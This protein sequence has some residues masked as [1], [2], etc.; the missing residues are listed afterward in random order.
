MHQEGQGRW[1]HLGSAWH[2]EDE[3]L[4]KA[5]GVPIRAHS[6]R[7]AVPLWRRGHQALQ[8]ISNADCC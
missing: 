1:Q 2:G 5:V 7:E 4:G 3:A 6:R 8:R